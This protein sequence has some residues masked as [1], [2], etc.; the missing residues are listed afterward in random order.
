MTDREPFLRA[1]REAPDD[2]GPRLVYADWLSEQGDPWG[3]LIRAECALVEMDPYHAEYPALRL[4]RERAYQAGRAAWH[5]PFVVHTPYGHAARHLPLDRGLIAATALTLDELLDLDA[6]IADRHPLGPTEVIVPGAILDD[7]RVPMGPLQP[8]RVVLTSDPYFAVGESDPFE[9]SDL[10]TAESR[11]YWRGALADIV[12][13]AWLARMTALTLPGFLLPDLVARLAD[14][15]ALRTVRLQ[16]SALPADLAAARAALG[17]DGVI[18]PPTAIGATL[19]VSTAPLDAVAERLGVLG[20]GDLA[21]L[22]VRP[23]IAA[24]AR[25][26]LS[27]TAIQERDLVA[28]L[29]ADL[30]GVRELGVD[31]LGRKHPQLVARLVDNPTLRGLR[32]VDLH[33]TRVEDRG[34]AELLGAGVLDGVCRLDLR[35]CGIKDAGVKTLVAHPDACRQLTALDLGSN[36]LSNVALSALVTSPDLQR[37]GEL[38][39]RNNRRLSAAGLRGLLE[40]GALPHLF[41]LDVRTTKIADDAETLAALRARIPRVEA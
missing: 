28:L 32:A 22:V 7:P 23:D 31:G 33:G 38:S 9:W 35:R 1:V 17:E 14:L 19:D 26:P 2:D 37:L 15:P 20:P 18:E 21:R 5:D 8:V 41:A 40:D 29:A 39:V 24:L 13:S 3:E 10:G 16:T 4:R 27:N 34:L 36:A 12:G 6:A 11:D 30:T 25:L